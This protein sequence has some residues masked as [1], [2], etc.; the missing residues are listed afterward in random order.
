MMPCV[1]FVLTPWI[2]NGWMGLQ[3]RRLLQVKCGARSRLPSPKELPAWGTRASANRL[4][5][6]ALRLVKITTDLALLSPT[7]LFVAFFH[8]FIFIFIFV[9]VISSF[10]TSLFQAQQDIK[11]DKKML[12]NLWKFVNFSFMDCLFFFG[13]FF[14]LK[15]LNDVKWREEKSLWINWNTTTFQTS[16]EQ[17]YDCLSSSPEC[18]SNLALRH[19]NEHRLHHKKKQSDSSAI[20]PNAQFKYHSTFTRSTS[21][22]YCSSETESELYAPYNFY[23]GDEV[24][25]IP[26]D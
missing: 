26:L 3:Q 23:T 15:K 20:E 10:F 13:F 2:D 21:L 18:D 16:S 17:A 6:N 11:N 24:C 7:H 5:K 14:C 9:F 25:N 12:L 8:S 22:P 19:G 4:W 1:S